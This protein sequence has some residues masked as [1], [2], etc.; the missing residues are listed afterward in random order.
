LDHLLSKDAILD[1][2][3]HQIFI[4]R[5][6]L[7]RFDK[8]ATNLQR[9]SK[10]HRRITG[11]AFAFPT[12]L[13]TRH[14]L[15][16]IRSWTTHSSLTSDAHS[17]T[18]DKPHSLAKT[19]SSAARSVPS[20]SQSNKVCRSY[21]SMKRSFHRT[22][23]KS[24]DCRAERNAHCAGKQGISAIIPKKAANQPR[25]GVLAAERIRV[26]PI[27]W[28]VKFTRSATQ[29]LRVAAKHIANH[30]RSRTWRTLLANVIRLNGFGRKSIVA[31]VTP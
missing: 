25:R 14:N 29:S 13:Q 16:D 1:N 19:K 11:G 4:S 12:H 24:P 2:K 17:I 28:W 9:Y 15:H 10:P 31:D 7:S 30:S 23:R 8:L 22:S 27:L 18:P 3:D 20:R 21:S 26:T 6:C 5:T